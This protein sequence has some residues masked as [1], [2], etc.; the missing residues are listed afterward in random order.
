MYLDHR[1]VDSK[2]NIIVD[3]YVTKGNE[4]TNPY[5]S[6]LEYIKKNLDFIIKKLLSFR[7][8]I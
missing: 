3:S 4:M 2:C 7:Y 1:T 6:R 8:D 5:F